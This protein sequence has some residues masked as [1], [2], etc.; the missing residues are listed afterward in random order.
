MCSRSRRLGITFVPPAPIVLAFGEI[1]LTAMRYVGE[2]MNKKV[3]FDG[4]ATGTVYPFGKRNTIY[5]DN[6]D[7]VFMLGDQLE[8]A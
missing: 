5:V 2:D 6:R 3:V 1:G 4:D 8:I 7:L